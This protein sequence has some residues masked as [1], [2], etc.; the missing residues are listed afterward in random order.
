[1]A[2]IFV[3]KHRGDRVGVLRECGRLQLLQDLAFFRGFPEHCDYSDGMLRER[4][5]LQLAQRT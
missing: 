5:R 1:M 4:R 3:F 2:P